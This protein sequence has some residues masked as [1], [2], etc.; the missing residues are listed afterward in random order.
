MEGSGSPRDGGQ[1]VG[2]VQLPEPSARSGTFGSRSRSSSSLVSQSTCD[3]LQRALRESAKGGG[4]TSACGIRR[5]APVLLGQAA[6]GILPLTPGGAELG[7]CTKPSQSEFKM[8]EFTI[9][10][11]S[12]KSKLTRLH[13]LSVMNQ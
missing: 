10:N 7:E 2:W 11:A 13:S 12:L 3:L 6:V 9:S 1:L 8:Y 4:S 5:E